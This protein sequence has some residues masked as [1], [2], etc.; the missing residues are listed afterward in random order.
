MQD[1]GSV[2]TWLGR[3]RAGEVSALGQLH[4]RYWTFL[5]GLANRKLKGMPRRDADQEDVAQ[6]ARTAALEL[7]A[8]AGTLLEQPGHLART[9][10]RIG[11]GRV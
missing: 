4:R 3:L 9:I 1:E 10:R 8:R 11:P 6:E 5:V 2:T 7:K